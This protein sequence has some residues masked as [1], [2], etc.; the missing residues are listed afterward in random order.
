MK[1]VLSLF[2]TLCA[3]LL[4][5][6][7]QTG[8]GADFAK[9]KPGMEKSEVLEIMGSPDRTQRW[10]GMDRWT[11]GLYESQGVRSEKEI[12][13]D[14]G[15][16][17]Y[18]GDR[19]PPEVTAEDQDSRNEVANREVEERVK[20]NRDEASRNLEKYETEVRGT[21]ETSYVPQFEPVQ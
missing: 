11:Y 1:S 13:F 3:L 10:R 17:T 21:D 20:K 15:K 7:C 12:H 9:L 14:Q 19:V 8:T 16:A 2:P 18:L 4:N 5:L 6:G